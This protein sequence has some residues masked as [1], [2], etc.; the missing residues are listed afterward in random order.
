ML[1]Y[2]SFFLK[3]LSFS[4]VVLTVGFILGWII[5]NNIILRDVSLKEALF[6]KDN[7]A[8]WIE[9]IGAFVFPV[10]Y[11]AGHG[12][13][14]S[15]SDNV[16]VDLA[17][18]L[19][20]TIFYVAILTLLR[21]LSKYCVNVINGKDKH[22]KICLNKEI[23]EQ[24]NIGAALFSVSLSVI[25]VSIIKYID[26]IDIINGLGLTILIE[27]LLFL[28][29]MLVALAAYSLILRRKTTL[30][31]ELFIDNNPAAGIGLLGFVFA[32]Q[33]I[34]SGVMSY[35]SM[36]FDLLT[37]AIV[38]GVSLV[39]FGILSVLFKF[40]FTKIV[41]VDVWN[42]VYEQDNVGAAI[43]QVALYVG[44]ASIIVNFIA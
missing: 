27:A 17:V 1:E 21:L 16:F 6:T 37:V 41:K 2:V 31:K 8:V 10:L 12:L 26:F 15:V 19:G 42:E 9:F 4:F 36:D 38:I 35:Y 5:Y 43:G 3:D 13:K 39:V 32:V 34:I 7:L 20:Y 28:V 44:I 14:G 30:F 22:G 18:C 11:L 23:C 29:F 25:F 24:K 40:I 33:T